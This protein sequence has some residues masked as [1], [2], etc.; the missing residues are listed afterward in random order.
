MEFDIIKAQDLKVLANLIKEYLR[1]GWV[2]HG[3]LVE[4]SGNYLQ[5]VVRHPAKQMQ[6]AGARQK[7]WI[8]LPLF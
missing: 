4:Q 7:S 8:R 5:G 3:E 2:L 1:G 6:K